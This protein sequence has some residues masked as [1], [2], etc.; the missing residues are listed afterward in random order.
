MASIFSKNLRLLRQ[1][2][3]LTQT[4]AS[5]ALGISQA[6]L[7]HY[8]NDMREPGLAFINRVCDYYHVSA[9]YLLGRTGV[10]EPVSE[11]AAPAAENAEGSVKSSARS[12]AVCDSTAILFDLLEQLPNDK[13][14]DAAQQYMGA[15]IYRLYRA[16]SNASP[17]SSKV[18]LATENLDF[19]H[20]ACN[21]DLI[22]DEIEY[23]QALSELKDVK[24][25]FPTCNYGALKEKYP[26]LYQSL[27]RLVYEGNQRVNNMISAHANQE[28]APEGEILEDL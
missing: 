11:E 22:L 21:A 1:E 8:E 27:F 20:S 5:A 24:G 2:N 7:S 19:V 14:A 9:D 25:A 12:S 6:L 23:T 16:L 26:A 18:L 17:D 15:A 10:R 13:A 3:Q 28:G 4:T